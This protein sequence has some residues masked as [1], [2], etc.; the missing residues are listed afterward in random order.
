MEKD[1][2]IMPCGDCSE[3]K[4]PKKGKFTREDLKDCSHVKKEFHGEHIWVRI[5]EVL[6]DGVKGTIDNDPVFETTPD[7]GTEVF[8]KYSEIEDVY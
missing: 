4:Y 6:D 5:T 3:K 1:N 2:A 7:Y 8:V